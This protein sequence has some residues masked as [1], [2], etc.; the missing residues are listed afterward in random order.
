MSENKISK[1]ELE[2]ARPGKDKFAWPHVIMLFCPLL[3]TR[4]LG[5]NLLLL[6]LVN[7]Q[8]NNATYVALLT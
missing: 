8:F 1:T 7:R 4:Q 3:K 2:N 5:R 6:A